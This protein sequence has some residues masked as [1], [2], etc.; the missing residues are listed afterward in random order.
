[1]SSNRARSAVAG[2][3]YLVGAGPGDPGLITLRGAECLRRA[4]VVLY[5]YLVNP[6]VLEHARRG[7]ELVCLG[8]HGHGR[9]LSQREINDRMVAEARAGRCVVR[10]KGGDPVVFAHAAEEVTAL[11]AAGIP[12]EIVPGITA[13][14]AAGSYAGIPLTQ[15]EGASAVALVTG[16]CSRHTPCAV[17]ETRSVPATADD[18]LAALDFAALARFP[19]TLVIYMGVTSAPR[20]TAELIAG[21]KPPGTPAAIIRRCSWPDQTIVTCT[22]ARVPEEIERRKLRPPV[23]VV[24]GDVAAQPDAVNWF[25]RRPLFGTRVMVTRPAHQAASL[26]DPLEE[27]GAEVLVQPAIEIGPPEDWGPVDRA[28]AE[29]ERFDWVVFSS[30]NGVQ[31]FLDRLLSCHSERSEESPSASREVIRRAQNDVR[32]LGH[33]KLAAVGPGTAEAL[34]QYYLRA[35]VVPEEFRAESLAAA[36]AGEA[37]GRRFLLIRASRG[38]EVLAEELRAAGADVTQAVAYTSLD[39]PP[40]SDEARQLLAAGRLD[41]V[42][43]TSSAIARSLAKMFGDDLRKARLVSISP[44]TSQTLRELGYEP[45]AEAAEY[46]MP[47]VVRAIQDCHE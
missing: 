15:R 41:W 30:A 8:R 10:L 1:L 2:K 38:R 37:R 12:F 18:D 19:G 7:A 14:L 11:S 31:Y 44:V 45:A 20:W 13:A 28:V 29:L 40:P 5:D 21:G 27:L 26:R 43:V 46:T 23:I 39:A 47:G 6:P 32:R 16:Q 22:L 24:V 36:L 25:T 4:D 17:D 33:V 9:I 35:D 3:V 42:T 34:A